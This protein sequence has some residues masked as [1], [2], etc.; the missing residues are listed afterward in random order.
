M[1][2]SVI[3][4]IDS[5]LRFTTFKW[6]D[7]FPIIKDYELHESNDPLN[8]PYLEKAKRIFQKGANIKQYCFEVGSYYSFTI[9]LV[10]LFI[11]TNLTVNSK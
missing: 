6:N 11:F 8:S 3:R 1:I 7:L 10:K 9:D 5:S 4:Y 2:Y